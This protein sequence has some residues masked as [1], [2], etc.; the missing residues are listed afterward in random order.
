[1]EYVKYVSWGGGTGSKRDVLRPPDTTSCCASEE[2]VSVF[3][4]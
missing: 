3:E 4:G 2:Y 1:M